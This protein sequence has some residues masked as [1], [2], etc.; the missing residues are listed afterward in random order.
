[1]EFISQ[2]EQLKETV[3]SYCESPKRL[4]IEINKLGFD[5]VKT[6]RNACVKY[7]CRNL[8]NRNQKVTI[9]L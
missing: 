5:Y 3:Y 1:M 2:K 4:Q 6:R 7:I 9:K 8:K